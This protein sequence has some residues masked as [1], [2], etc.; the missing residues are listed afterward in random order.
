VYVLPDL[1]WSLD[2]GFNVERLRSAAAV[3]QATQEFDV[4]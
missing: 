3:K 1:E 2:E 4:E